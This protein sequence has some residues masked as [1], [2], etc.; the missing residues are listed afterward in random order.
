MEGEKL[1]TVSMDYPFKICKIEEDKTAIEVGRC[2]V[3]IFSL[4]AGI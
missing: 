4:K 3:K 1:G 2:R